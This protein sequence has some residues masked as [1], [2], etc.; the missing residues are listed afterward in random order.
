MNESQYHSLIIFN[1]LCEKPIVYFLCKLNRFQ[2]FNIFDE[3]F[4]QVPSGISTVNRK[5][6]NY[7]F[8]NYIFYITFVFL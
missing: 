8:L 7:F 6:V 1:R 4:C 5:F 2:I 3:A